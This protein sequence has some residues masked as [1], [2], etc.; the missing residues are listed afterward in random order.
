[1]PR[2][3]LFAMLLLA[4]PSAALAQLSQEKDVPWKAQA[5]ILRRGDLVER[6]DG[7]EGD[8]LAFAE[9]VATPADDSGKWFI[10]IVTMK[11][12]APC[13]RLRSDFKTEA[14]LKAWVNV[15]DY[16]QS[17]AHWQVF[18]IED[19]SQEK[20]WEQRKPKGFPCVI[21]QPPING[22]FGDP[23]NVVYWHEG[24][25]PA[26]RLDREMREAIQMYVKKV[27]PQRAEWK[28]KHADAW[29]ARRGGFEQTAGGFTPPVPAPAPLGPPNVTPFSVPPQVSGAS[30][31]ELRA[32]L[33]DAPA[34]FVLQQAAKKVTV[35]VALAEWRAER[36][37][38]AD[39][40]A[41][42]KAEEK[43]AEEKAAERAEQ[44]RLFE[45]LFDRLERQ[46]THSQP[47]SEP[48]A[49]TVTQSE[50]PEIG[51]AVS[52]LVSLATGGAISIAALATVGGGVLGLVLWIR[53]RRKA[54]GKQL[55]I[56]DTTAAMLEKA[57][58]LLERFDSIPDA[59]K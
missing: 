19:Q 6:V 30:V 2:F 8:S 50:M 28:A 12:C 57:E 53:S 31:E 46:E 52:T 1:M 23:R 9:A 26:E 5:E 51:P 43:A 59:P 35:D 34:E 4:L 48:A 3:A 47:A 21:I 25:L 15:E 17:W 32:A 10:S 56:N 20:R 33:P 22:S 39:L 54:A 37:R 42:K 44:R 27:G 38:Q 29:L 13:E 55:L 7:F 45:R 18:Q 58:K 24:Y 14:K 40:E 49:E 36:Q 11:G 16:K 41:K